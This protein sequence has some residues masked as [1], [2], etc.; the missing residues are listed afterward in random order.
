MIFWMHFEPQWK[1]M[2][3]LG[4]VWNNSR[5]NILI[6]HLFQTSYSCSLALSYRDTSHQE[7]T[8]SKAQI[9]PS[10]EKMVL[11]SLFFRPGFDDT[12]PKKPSLYRRETSFASWDWERSSRLNR[13]VLRMWWG[14]SNWDFLN[15][16]FICK[17]PPQNRWSW[18]NI[19]SHK[20]RF[21]LL[22]LEEPNIF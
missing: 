8:H 13:S 19:L 3:I 22:F 10:E 9:F 5:L 14:I 6:W 4:W 11:R 1:S 18:S 12:T 17:Q 2:T 15:F 21:Y 20:I 16:I 7:P